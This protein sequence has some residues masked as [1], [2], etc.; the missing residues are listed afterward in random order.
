MIDWLKIREFFESIDYWPSTEVGQLASKIHNHKLGNVEEHG[1]FFEERMYHHYFTFRRF[2][3]PS[4]LRRVSTVDGLSSGEKRKL[5]RTFTRVVQKA[6]YYKGPFKI[7]L[8]KE[9]ESVELYQLINAEFP[10][11]RFITILRDPEYFVKS[12]ITM[13]NACTVAKHG[14]DPNKIPGWNEANIQF[15]LNECEKMIAFCL[16]LEARKAIFYITYNEYTRHIEDTVR[17]LYRFLDMA[18]SPQY[19]DHLISLQDKQDQRESGYVNRNQDTTIF[20]AYRHFV[21]LKGARA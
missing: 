16:G 19:E 13:S 18:I 4:I 17:K 6:A 21:D 1:I 7:W 14:V 8:T 15:R 12:Y 10:G 11:G 3:F 2:P 9:N 5:M 20:G